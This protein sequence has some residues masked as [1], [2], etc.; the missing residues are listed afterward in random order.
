MEGFMTI[1]QAAAFIGVS[2][3]RVQQW[4]AEGAIKGAE[5]I[6][7]YW[8]IPEVEVKRLAAERPRRQVGRPRKQPID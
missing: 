7:V 8:L 4:L 1:A 2:R 5:K 3:Q 6:G